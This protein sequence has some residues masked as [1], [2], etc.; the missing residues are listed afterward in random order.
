MTRTTIIPFVVCIL[1]LTGCR[2][3]PRGS[4]A[5]QPESA[6]NPIEAQRLTQQ[7]VRMLDRDPEKAERLLRDALSADIFHGPAHNNLGVIHLSRGELYEA[8]EEFEWARK[9]LPG[10]PDPRLNLAL[11][12]ERAGRVD[13]AIVEY[14]AALDVHPGHI[15]TIQAL[16]RCRLR[17]RPLDPDDAAAIDPDPEVA[18]S[19]RDIALRGE[20]QE[21]RDWAAKALALM[22]HE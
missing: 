13:D 10:L 21:W 4:Y 2:A 15:Q 3:A 22:R 7:A 9:L 20:T 14:R 1:A 19:L 6:R 18:S 17:H 5:V 16:T 11:T 12:L 8:A